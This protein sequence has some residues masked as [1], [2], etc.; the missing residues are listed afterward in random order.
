MKKY[1][2]T[3]EVKLP[4]LSPQE[5]PGK[6]PKV[7]TTG[8]LKDPDPRPLRRID[9]R[10]PFDPVINVQDKNHRKKYLTTSDLPSDLE[11]HRENCQGCGERS[12]Q[13]MARKKAKKEAKKA[14]EWDT[15]VPWMDLDGNFAEILDKDLYNALT[16][17]EKR[18]YNLAKGRESRKKKK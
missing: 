16:T 3:S 7:F 13:R 4:Y 12:A 14:Q 2:T 6:K 10:K 17:E 9:E 1:K 18:A 8:K 11:K 5:I 15:I